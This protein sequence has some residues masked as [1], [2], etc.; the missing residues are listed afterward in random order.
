MN[1]E[2][3]SQPYII[4]GL[5]YQLY[6]GVVPNT[7]SSGDNPNSNNNHPDNSVGTYRHV[8]PNSSTGRILSGLRGPQVFLGDSEETG[9]R[10]STPASASVRAPYIPKKTPEQSTKNS[11]PNN[12]TLEDVVSESIPKV[13]ETTEPLSNTNN[14]IYIVVDPS[15]KIKDFRQIHNVFEAAKSY[16]GLDSLTIG[17]LENLRSNLG[18]ENEKRFSPIV[19]VYDS[20]GLN[21]A[22]IPKGNNVMVHVISKE[23]LIKYLTTKPENTEQP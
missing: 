23:D 17:N 19:G 2:S 1:N 3:K 5:P 8:N 10:T 14:N 15:N 7:Y 20:K 21:L 11:Q 4:N 22:Q 13:T 18:Y 9:Y 12:T 16:S 6:R